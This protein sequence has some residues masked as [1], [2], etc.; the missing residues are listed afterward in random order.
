MSRKKRSKQRAERAM[1]RQEQKPKKNR[2]QEHDPA[3]WEAKKAARDKARYESGLKCN[4][5]KH[6]YV[7]L[8]KY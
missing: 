8:E 2:K 1:K 5:P 6:D 4:S 7:K 3:K